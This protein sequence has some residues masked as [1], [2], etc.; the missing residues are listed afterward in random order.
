MSGV[1]WWV[2]WGGVVGGVGWDGVVGGSFIDFNV[3]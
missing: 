2:D 1:G 3:P